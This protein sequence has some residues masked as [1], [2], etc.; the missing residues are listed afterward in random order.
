MSLIFGCD[1]PPP[2]R[3]PSLFALPPRSV[4]QSNG[5]YRGTSAS[6]RAPRIAWFG[7]L[8][9]PRSPHAQVRQTWS[10]LQNAC[11]GRRRGVWVVEKLGGYVPPPWPGWIAARLGTGH[12]ASTPRR[13]RDPQCI[14]LFLICGRCARPNKEWCEPRE[15]WTVLRLLPAVSGQPSGS[16]PPLGVCANA[17]RE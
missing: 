5:R 9:W 14:I 8:D 7:R 15:V 4:C 6:L 1:K 3:R 11:R 16:S 2:I 17:P 13:E 12:T 10:V